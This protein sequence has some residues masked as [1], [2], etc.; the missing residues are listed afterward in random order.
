MK[1]KMRKYRAAA[2]DEPVLKVR[3]VSCQFLLKLDPDRLGKMLTPNSMSKPGNA[4]VPEPEGIGENMH[5]Y[6]AYQRR[7]NIGQHVSDYH[8]AVIRIGHG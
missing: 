7:G 8:I 2:A 3:Q 1:T 6:G 4:I 5:S